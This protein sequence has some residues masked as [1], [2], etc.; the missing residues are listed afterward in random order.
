MR[1]VIGK[2]AL[3]E[4]GGVRGIEEKMREVKNRDLSFW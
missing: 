2:R 1:T 3:Y 4:G